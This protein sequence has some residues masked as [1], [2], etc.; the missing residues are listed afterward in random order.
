MIVLAG[1]IGCGA[2]EVLAT[3]VSA[4]FSISP[5]PMTLEQSMCDASRLLEAAAEQAVRSFYAGFRAASRAR[6]QTMPERT[7]RFCGAA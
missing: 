6:A 1:A 3:G 5:C 4:Y 2:E 7:L